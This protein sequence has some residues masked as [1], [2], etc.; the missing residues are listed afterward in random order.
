[1]GNVRELRN[2]ME[3]AVVLCTGDVIELHH[4]CVDSPV[5]EEPAQPV[6]A[7]PSAERDALVE[8]LQRCGGNQTQAARLLGISRRTLLAR[9]DQLGLPRPRKTPPPER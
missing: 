9:L 6:A 3:R 2:L 5:V 4:F 8:A 1:P 7:A